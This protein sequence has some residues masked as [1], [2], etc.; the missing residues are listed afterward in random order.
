MHP[1]F[2]EMDIPR[3]PGTT[4]EISSYRSIFTF[5]LTLSAFPYKKM[6]LYYQEVEA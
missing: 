6:Q 2:C 1:I 5:Q 3:K 4:N